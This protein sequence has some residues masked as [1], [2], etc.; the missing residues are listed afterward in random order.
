MSI[1]Q[2]LGIHRKSGRLAKESKAMSVS[3][4]TDIWQL[5]VGADRY[6]GKLF[7]LNTRMLANIDS[8]NLGI[9][10]RSGGVRTFS[11]LFSIL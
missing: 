3:Y 7:L 2:I 1:C 9:A 5:I 6:L 8:T 4:M 11:I 10:L